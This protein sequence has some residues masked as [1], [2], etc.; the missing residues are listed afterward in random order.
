MHLCNFQQVQSFWVRLN[1]MFQKQ[2]QV[3]IVF[4]IK[5]ADFD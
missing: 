1:F 3:T 2:E 5:N 4:L